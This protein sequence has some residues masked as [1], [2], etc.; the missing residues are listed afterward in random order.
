MKI[1]LCFI[2]NYEH[3]LN[4]EYLWRE[5]IDHNKDIINV[6]FYY[7]DYEKIKSDWIKSHALPQNYIYETS[8][9]HVIPAYISLMDYAIKHDSENKW[10][11][12]LTDSC[13]PIISP[14]RFRYLFYTLYS[15]SIFSW[16]RAWWNIKVHRRG[17][18]ALL[19]EEYH[20]A[21]DPWFILNRE[22]VMQVLE[23]IKQNTT[24]V[25]I[26]C[27]GGLANESLFAIILHIYGQLNKVIC[28]PSHMADWSRMASPTSPHVF[29]EANQKD[30][31]F[32]EDN[33]E[34]NKATMFIRKVSV[35][36]PDSVLRYYIYLHF[37]QEDDKL[38]IDELFRGKK[39]IMYLLYSVT[40]II[41][42]I[43]LKIYHPYNILL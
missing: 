5:W 1:A 21:N 18:L 13:C 8:Y 12:F 39:Y 23:L 3:I 9:Y 14:K 6:Y 11:C 41:F 33:L 4:K 35:D 29:N 20:L 36:F 28:Q 24:L 25:K 30:I 32:I 19:P 22:H 7:K 17:N 42:Y 2:I 43:Y 16:K 37:K 38:I 10:F 40:L 26:V 34:K 31:E 27:D 15:V